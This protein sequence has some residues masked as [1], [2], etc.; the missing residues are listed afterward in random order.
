MERVVERA[1]RV[2]RAVCAT[3]TAWGLLKGQPSGV[4]VAF[5]AVRHVLYAT[6]A[7]LLMLFVPR[8]VVGIGIFILVVH[9]YK[10]GRFLGDN[11]HKP[12]AQAPPAE[13]HVPLSATANGKAAALPEP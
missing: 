9:M 1:V 8:A 11:A 10:L 5:W 4:L 2:E 7:V 13:P 6:V 12:V 3:G